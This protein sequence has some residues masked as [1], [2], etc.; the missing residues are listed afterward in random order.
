MIRKENEANFSFVA[1]RLPIVVPDKR[2]P[3]ETLFFDLYDS[4]GD[5]VART[6]VLINDRLTPVLT[7][8]PVDPVESP[9]GIPVPSEDDGGT[10][11]I[12][13]LG[14][15]IFGPIVPGISTGSPFG[16]VGISTNTVGII[17]DV[18]VD[19]PGF[20]YT[21][22]DFVRFGDCVYN[23]KVTET[24]SIVGVESA[25]SCSSTYESNPGEGVIT[26]QNGQAARLFPVLQFTPL[27]K[28]ITIVNQLG[29]ISVVD[30]V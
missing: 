28:K 13:T 19:R 25:S 6:K 27:T 16:G 20:G 22:G 17:T 21:S 9:P 10:S 5:Y 2:E 1:A 7:P 12:G 3:I 30:C 14:T 24:G 8:E 11:G 4:G 18:I 26:T 15:T 23:L 29:V